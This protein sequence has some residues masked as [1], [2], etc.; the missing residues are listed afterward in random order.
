MATENEI[1]CVFQLLHE[2]VHDREKYREFIGICRV[3]FYALLK[4]FKAI[5]FV[6]MSGNLGSD[7]YEMFCLFSGIRINNDILNISFQVS[8]Q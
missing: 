3:L 6:H 2:S 1:Q 5:F 4:C 8:F 7:F